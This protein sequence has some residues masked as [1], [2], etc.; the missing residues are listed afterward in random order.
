M[1]EGEIM[2]GYTIVSVFCDADTV[3][4]ATDELARNGI[5]L[6]ER[7]VIHGRHGDAAA[8]TAPSAADDDVTQRLT[9]RD[10]PEPDARDYADAVEHGY[11]LLVGHIDEAHVDPATD[12]LNRHGAVD[13]E[14]GI[15]TDSGLTAAAADLRTTNAGAAGSGPRETLADADAARRTESALKGAAPATGQGNAGNRAGNRTE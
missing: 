5:A 14:D 2:A 1:E 15:A 13:L 9:R 3:G 6:E 4:R 10:V 8:G 12:I 7:E 11:T